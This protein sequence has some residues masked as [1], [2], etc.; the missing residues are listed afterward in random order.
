MI[1]ASCALCALVRIYMRSYMGVTPGQKMMFDVNNHKVNEARAQLGEAWVL[2]GD[3]LDRQAVSH[4]FCEMRQQHCREQQRAAKRRRSDTDLQLWASKA[5]KKGC[6][7][8]HIKTL[9]KKISG[10]PFCCGRQRQDRFCSYCGK[11]L[12]TVL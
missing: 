1:Y 10:K 8:W 9:K 3:E 6:V 2:L 11:I 7:K 4:A 12:M 5:L